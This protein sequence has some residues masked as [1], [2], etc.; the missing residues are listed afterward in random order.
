MYNKSLVL[1]TPAKSVQARDVVFRVFLGVCQRGHRD[2]R[3]NAKARPAHVN[4]DLANLD[5]RG[6]SVVGGLLHPR[7][8]L[9]SVPGDDLIVLAQA[10]TAPKAPL[11]ARMES[12]HQVDAPLLQERD[13]EV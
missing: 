3:F 12:S 2:K 5:R 4:T 1:F 10:A 7:R 8:S 9:G 6:H 11:S 13:H